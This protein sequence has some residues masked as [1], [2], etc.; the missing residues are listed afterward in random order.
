MK[1]PSMRYRCRCCNPQSAGDAL[2]HDRRQLMMGLMALAALPVL[3]ACDKEGEKATSVAP[4]A[5]AASAVPLETIAT[6]PVSGTGEPAPLV[7]PVA[8]ISTSVTPDAPVEAAT[9]VS[10]VPLV[11][12]SRIP[13]APSASKSTLMRPP[14]RLMKAPPMVS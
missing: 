8:A 13:S 7:P 2:R 1:K 11:P 6:D 5:G 4:G 12:R 9:I 10:A 14:P 3:G